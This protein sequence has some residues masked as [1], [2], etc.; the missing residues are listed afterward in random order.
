MLNRNAMARW[1][2]LVVMGAIAALP[3]SARAQTPVAP[4]APPTIEVVKPEVVKADATTPVVPEVNNGIIQANCPSCGLPGTAPLG[5]GVFG[6][7][8]HDRS[9]G[10]LCDGCGSGSCGDGGCGSCGEGSCI[11]GRG[12]CVTCEGQSRIGRLF[13]AFHNA[14]CCP[15]P[16]Y[17]PR[18]IDAAN[19]GMFLDS[20]RPWTM[21][22]IRYSALRN[23]IGANRGELFQAA[24]G[25]GPGVLPTVSADNISFYQEVSSGAFSLIVDTPYNSVSQGSGFGDL[26]I[27]TKTLLLD[28]ELITSSFQFMTY[29]PVGNSTNGTG[30]GH[31]TLDPSL[32]GTVKLFT[33][34]YMQ[35][36]LGL[37]IPIGGTSSAQSEVMHY[38]AS[39]NHVLCRPLPD[40]AIIAN[41]EAVGYTFFGGTVT[42]VNGVTTSGNGTIFTLGPTLRMAICN[43]I[44][45]GFGVQFATTAVRLAE[46]QYRTEIRWRY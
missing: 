19:S 23:I 22:R 24:P 36:Q 14:L 6:N 13:C 16:C 38:H 41:F 32:L 4:L 17:E 28:S 46:E 9:T 2:M 10:L 21:S 25:R 18:W 3:T 40:T 15:D 43:K 30:T 35:T 27:G 37:Y 5:P 34:T 31:T 45:V 12:P 1:G 8:H 42:D 11:P 33:E 29:I 20:A 26:G 39:F 7:S 44:D